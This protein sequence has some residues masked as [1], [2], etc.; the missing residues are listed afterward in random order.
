MGRKEFIKKE[1]QGKRIKLHE[2]ISKYHISL[3]TSEAFTQDAFPKTFERF[4]NNMSASCFQKLF[5]KYRM[6]Q[7]LQSIYFCHIKLVNLYI[8]IC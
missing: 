8:V 6:Y 5:F 7:M 4:L 2:H 1:K 3:I